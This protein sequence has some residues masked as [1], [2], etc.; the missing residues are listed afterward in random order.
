[1]SDIS[2]NCPSCDQ[3]LEAPDE[4]AGQVIQCP[5]CE[6]EIEVP[7]PA[8]PAVAADGTPCPSCGKNIPKGGVLCVGCGYHIKLGKK[9]DTQL[10]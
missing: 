6:T 8:V 2:F 3:A 4:Y 1:M 10:S 5:S 9:I 7:A